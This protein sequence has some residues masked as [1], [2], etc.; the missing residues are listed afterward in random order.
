MMNEVRASVASGT[1][2]DIRRASHSLKGP[3]ANFT[4]GAPTQAALAL[5]TMARANQV[6]DAPAALQDLERAIADFLARLEQ[7]IGS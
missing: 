5:E 7:F 3:V 2:D 4:D 1:A 6:A